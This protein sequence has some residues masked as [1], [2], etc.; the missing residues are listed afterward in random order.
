[1]PANYPE[2]WG[3]DESR[4]WSEISGEHRDDFGN[5]RDDPEAI[6]RFSAGWLED[7]YSTAE[8][9]AIRDSFFDYLVEQG[10]DF[11]REDFDWAAW[12]EY[13]GY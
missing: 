8:R 13:M 6:A 1:M 2:F 9:N 3:G 11:D 4:L 10:Y 7:G 5:M 12:R